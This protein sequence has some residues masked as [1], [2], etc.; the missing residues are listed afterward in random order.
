MATLVNTGTQA[1]VAAGLLL[2]TNSPSASAGNGLILQIGWLDAVAGAAGTPPAPA[3]WSVGFAALSAFNTNSVGYS[4]FYKTATGGV[5]SPVFTVPSGSTMY[6]HGIITEWSGMGA[7]D[8]ASTGAA[9]TNSAA[10]STTGV[11]V[12]NTGTLA[13]A[14][15]TIFTGVAIG[16][17]AG[18]PNAAIAF[19]GGAWSTLIS[20]QDTGASVGTLVGDKVVSSNAALGAVYTWTADATMRTYQAA[21]TVFSDLSNSIAWV[22]A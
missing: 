17:G 14:K 7:L 3:G 2:T 5:E 13:N 22:K 4:L 12:P 11:T 20:A 21:V 16:A 10:A 9:A 8:P 19:S 15:S 18:L 6:A 1:N